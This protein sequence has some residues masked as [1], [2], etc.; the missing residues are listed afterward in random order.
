MVHSSS[1]RRRSGA[2]RLTGET[3]G[4]RLSVRLSLLRASGW[5]VGQNAVRLHRGCPLFCLRAIWLV[6]VMVYG[7]DPKSGD[8]PCISLNKGDK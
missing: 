4:I 7:S 3:V 2:E 5:V 8:D 6:V 1:N